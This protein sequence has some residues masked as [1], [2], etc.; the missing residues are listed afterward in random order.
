MG[1]EESKMLQVQVTRLKVLGISY[2]YYPFVSTVSSATY[3]LE[4][5]VDVE[6]ARGGIGPDEV[7]GALQ[8]GHP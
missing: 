6:G 8:A 7:R 4:A 3:V 1:A 2:Q 5:T